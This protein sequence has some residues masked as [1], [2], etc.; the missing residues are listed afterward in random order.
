[1]KDLVKKNPL[2]SQLAGELHGNVARSLTAFSVFSLVLYSAIYFVTPIFRSNPPTFIG[3]GL[4]LFAVAGFRQYLSFSI[5]QRPLTKGD[6]RV[7]L[8]SAALIVSATTWGLFTSYVI[9][10]FLISWSTFF[11]A[12]ICCAVAV[13][14]LAILQSQ[15]ALLTASLTVHLIPPVLTCA[16][17]LPGQNGLSFSVFFAAFWGL[18]LK[19]GYKQNQVFWQNIKTSNKINAIVDALPG[20]LFWLD[21][22]QKLTGWNQQFQQSFPDAEGGNLPDGVQSVVSKVYQGEKPLE[23]VHLG[24]RTFLISGQMFNEGTEAVMMGMDV[25]G[26]EVFESELEEERQQLLDN[27]EYFELGEVFHLYQSWSR[28][29]ETEV[30]ENHG[31]FLQIFTEEIM[32][33]GPIVEWALA[34]SVSTKQYKIELEKDFDSTLSTF[35]TFEPKKLFL[36]L[37]QILKNSVDALEDVEQ[38]KIKVRLEKNN[39]MVEITIKDN[40]PGIDPALGDVVFEP[41]ISTK[42]KHLG[43]G[44]CL[45]KEHLSG[46]ANV[47]I[48]NSEDGC[49]M[50]VEFQPLNFDKAVG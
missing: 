9:Y 1:M 46:F 39:G 33:I 11:V 30:G 49:T 17:L 12:L 28:D 36:G 5:S 35:F 10:D 27:V 29:N 44:L 26:Q 25:S 18:L 4:A 50:K 42:E 38:P 32:N 37:F 16:L 31:D 40:G 48:G 14:Y 3:F 2:E 23:E 21:D 7:G 19:I 8:M 15:L 34:L 41:F 24:R 13:G 20:S 6:F 22:N 45:A 43:M 47:V